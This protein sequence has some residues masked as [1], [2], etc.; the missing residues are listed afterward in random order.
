MKK[1]ILIN[2]TAMLLITTALNTAVFTTQANAQ[3]AKNTNLS[4]SSS[5][6]VGRN[7]LANAIDGKLLLKA[8]VGYVYSFGGGWTKSGTGVT[9]DNQSTATGGF[10]YGVSLGY[11]NKSG[12]GVSADYLGFAH[13]WTGVGAGGQGNYNF[14]APYHVMTVTPSYRF[15]LD[16]ANRWGLR[17]GLGLGFSL[18]DISWKAA[19][20]P[21]GAAS[22]G[23]KVAGGAAY[24]I[25]QGAT[26]PNSGTGQAN[27]NCLGNGNFLAI[28]SNNTG[29]PASTPTNVC[30]D[31]TSGSP[32]R[33]AGSILTDAEIAS[34]FAIDATADANGNARAG[35]AYNSGTVAQGV[36]SDNAIVGDATAFKNMLVNVGV[37]NRADDKFEANTGTVTIANN[38]WTNALNF[39]NN[40]VKGLVKLLSVVDATKTTFAGNATISYGGPNG[41]DGYAS[42]TDA[43]R[44][45][46]V[47]KLGASATFGAVPDSA[48]AGG[49]GLTL[50]FTGATAPTLAYDSLSEA[51]LKDKAKDA[52]SLKT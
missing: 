44:G 33:V 10:G 49:K 23:T 25:G 21:S 34:L 43:Q 8:D 36:W 20:S 22:N 51:T 50:G 46:L 35:A 29:F 41:Y 31:R 39:S 4:S 6:A 38:V 5:V 18:S 24:S 13:K 47:T 7:M 15:A 16:R 28:D 1:N 32:V 48:W 19:G 3:T 37:S 14:D 45:L 12:W 42:F 26:V 52:N 40:S 17:L 30:L 2:A 27:A 9:G 11:T